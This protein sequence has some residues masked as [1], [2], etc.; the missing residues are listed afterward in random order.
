M[1]VNNVM[2]DAIVLIIQKHHVLCMQIVAMACAMELI[3]IRGLLVP[4][5]MILRV[6]VWQPMIVILCAFL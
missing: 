3:Q 5:A 4:V 1:Q 2:M 6:L